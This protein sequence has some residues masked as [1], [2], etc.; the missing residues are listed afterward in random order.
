MLGEAVQQKMTQQE[1]VE[2]AP[3]V[4]LVDT[5]AS[6]ACARSGV[7]VRILPGALENC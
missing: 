5:H 4:E 6:G 2:I 1:V 7:Q 3:V